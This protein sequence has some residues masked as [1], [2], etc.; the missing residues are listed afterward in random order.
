MRRLLV[1]LLVLAVLL[2]LA[3]RGAAL[4]A[5]RLVAD[6]LQSTAQLSARPDVT[7]EGFPFLTQAVRGRYESVRV[8]ATDLP[9][10]SMR[11]ARLTATLQG[12]QVPLSEVVTG[13]VDRVPVDAIDARVLVSYAELSRRSGSRALTVSAAG[14]LLRVRGS[15][16]VLGRTLAAA[17]LSRVTVQG[18]ELVITAQSYEVGNSVADAVLSRALGNRL[19]FRVDLSGLP[20]GLRVRSARVGPQGL[21]LSADSDGAVLSTG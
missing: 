13:A 16:R 17:A 12:V 5:G 4:L 14:D 1:S 9:A 18:Q 6:R 7:L 10:G 11:L 20:Y 15:V 21:T 2:V 3:D 19:D 8:V